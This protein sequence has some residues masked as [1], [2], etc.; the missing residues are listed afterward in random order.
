MSLS[1]GFQPLYKQVYDLLTTRLVEGYWKPSQLLPS[2]MVLAEELGVSQ[3]TVRKALNQMVAEKMLQ[4]Q[5][6]KGTFVA[7]HTQESDL[8]RFFRLREPHGEI[9][10]PETVVLGSSRRTV[11]EDEAKKL[12][13]DANA[14]VVELTRVRS[15][16]NKPAI[17][18]KVIQPLSVFPDIDKNTDLPNALYI[19]YQEKYGITVMSVNDEIR[20]VEIP[21]AYAQHLD[22]AK[23]SPVLMI[24]RSSVNIDGRVVELS[25]AYCSSENFVYSVQLT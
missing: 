6:G 2:E 25:T 10:I 21:D 11:S 17:I 18:E 20:A 7:E 4:R 5:Q 19:L 9:L 13:L 14:L 22:L 12:S 1:A 15:I 3:G 23:G 24:E 8:F 16:H